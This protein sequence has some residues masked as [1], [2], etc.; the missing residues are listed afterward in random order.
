MQP[1]DHALIEASRK[2]DAIAWQT[3]VERYQRLIY[4]V[5]RRAG[6]DETRAS[7]V[8]QKVFAKL[9]ANLHRIE[10]PDRIQAWLVTTAKRETIRMLQKEQRYAETAQD[11]SEQE[12]TPDHQPIPDEIVEKLEEQHL[13]RVAVSQVGDKCRHLLTLL[14][15][16][17]EPI[18]YQEIAGMLE[19]SEGS[20]GPT[21]ARCLQKV[22][23]V[24][25]KDGFF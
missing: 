10:Q 23:K 4:T 21:R 1:S 24:L 6:L 8:F 11:I 20:I 13:V 9:V 3:L 15:Y 7:D 22:Q 18:S 2:G 25:E 16:H 17:P 14:F 19:M 12:I 5:P